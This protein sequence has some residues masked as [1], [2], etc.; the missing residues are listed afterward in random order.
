MLSS[1]RPSRGTR[2]TA[3]EDEEEIARPAHRVLRFPK[4]IIA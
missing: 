3:K 1:C 2:D 4:T